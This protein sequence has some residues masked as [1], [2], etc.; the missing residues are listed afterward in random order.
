MQRLTRHL[1]AV[2]GNE[3]SLSKALN[4]TG[5]ERLVRFRQLKR[6]GIAQYNN[7]QLA[8]HGQITRERDVSS[9][10]EPVTCGTCHAV[11]S[12]SYF[13]RHRRLCTAVVIKNNCPLLAPIPL[14]VAQQ[15]KQDMWNDFQREILSRFRANEVGILCQTDDTIKM[16][17]LKMFQGVA[18]KIDKIDEVRKSVMANM[19]KL[20]GLYLQF[21]NV[22]GQNVAFSDMLRRQ[23]FQQFRAAVRHCDDNSDEESGVKTVKAGVKATLSHVI[24]SACKYVKADYLEHHKDDEAAEMDKFTA[25][26]AANYKNLFC[27]AVYHLNK[28]R[29]EKLCSPAKL[30]TQSDMTRLKQYTVQ[31]IRKLTN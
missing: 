13:W 12:K 8:R 1:A 20:A 29:Q 6:Q 28:I 25:V 2:H 19:W 27:D 30:P 26:L 11:I 14:T 9:E 3:T 7:E 5:K 10:K 21:K 22:K 24:N 17:G 4:S 16:I 23:N 31:K 18:T 15:E